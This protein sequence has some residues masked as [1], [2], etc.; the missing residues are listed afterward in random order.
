MVTC[1]ST[2]WAGLVQVHALASV[3]GCTIFSIY[4]NACRAIRLLF[5]GCIYPREV[6]GENHT[7]YIMWTRDGNFDSR[8]GALFQPNHFVPLLNPIYGIDSVNDFP[9]L[10]SSSPTIT[11]KTAVTKHGRG[12][13][14]NDQAKGSSAIG[15]KSVLPPRNKK[16]TIYE[17]TTQ[18][19]RAV[20]F[21]NTSPAITNISAKERG[22]KRKAND[23]PDVQHLKRQTIQ[24]SYEKKTMNSVPQNSSLSEP[25]LPAL[26]T[27]AVSVKTKNSTLTSS[28]AYTASRKSGSKRK[29]MAAPLD[30]IPFK[31]LSCHWYETQ[32]K[33][34]YSVKSESIEKDSSTIIPLKL[35]QSWYKRRGRLAKKMKAERNVQLQNKKEHLRKIYVL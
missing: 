13:N 26:G 9:L 22:N 2:K 24:G 10:T 7:L 17:H 27:E 29:T 33:Q 28:Q 20:L 14:G 31:H 19:P 21:S 8:P 15:R 1:V 3:L 4:P 25:K 12:K 34:P 16:K 23:N 5:H 30:V 35:S 11:L 32:I 18:R 6:H